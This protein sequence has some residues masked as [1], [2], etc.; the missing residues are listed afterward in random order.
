M[1]L[2]Y[3][4]VLL[5]VFVLLSANNVECAKILG[6]FNVAS[7][8]HQ[9][10]FQPIWKELSLRGHQVTVLTPNP[11]KDPLLVNLTEIDLSYLYR[12]VE[13]IKP[14]M[15]QSLGHWIMLEMMSFFMESTLEELFEHEEVIALIKSSGTK[16]DVV[17]A[18]TMTP[19][20][21]A[22]AWKFQCPLIGVASYS[23]TNPGHEA[24]GTPNH[25]VLY[26]DM[27]TTFTEDLTFLE[28]VEATIFYFWHRYRYFNSIYPM[29]NR[30]ARKYFGKNTPDAEELAKNM[31]M[32]F[33][34]TNPILHGPR[35][36]GPNVVQL[37]R[38]HLKPKRPLPKVSTK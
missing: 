26:P 10:V 28:K 12:S 14:Q 34:N 15:S 4:H 17:L 29:T 32:L 22:F 11:L 25:P 24:A 20:L 31:S 6:V 36:Y 21:Y 38:M 9:V 5:T 3:A 1:L 2:L 27:I 30:I 19:V 8:S 16:F 18:E 23:V 13:S 37:G 35:P 33:L 7:V